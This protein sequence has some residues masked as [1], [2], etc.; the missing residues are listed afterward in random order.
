M[1]VNLL[2]VVLIVIGL[3]FLIY[4]GKQMVTSLTMKA[5]TFALFHNKPA[6]PVINSLQQKLTAIHPII[7][8]LKIREG[9]ESF[10]LNKK[11]V[12]LCLKD[13]KTGELY[14]DNMLTYVLL[15][16][17]AHVINKDDV[18]H[19]PK[20]H[21]KFDE[22]LERATQLGLFDPNKELVEDYCI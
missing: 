18:G 22:L 14:D 17:I 8:S 15:H 7:G 5:E 2:T 11:D 19:T 21:K 6:H 9:K 3:F 16:E 4:Y 20:F 13:K 10:T 1:K 12:S